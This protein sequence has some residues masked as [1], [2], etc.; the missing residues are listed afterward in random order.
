MHHF[1]YLWRK[2]RVCA[3]ARE[4]ENMSTK[5]Q[6]PSGIRIPA[7]KAINI[8]PFLLA[9][10]LW[11]VL[12]F[13][14]YHY[15]RK[16]EDLS[17]FLF[18]R[19]FLIDGFRTPGG[20]LGIAG[21]FC[22]QFLHLPWL[23]SLIWVLLLVSSF[24]LTRKAFGIPERFAILGLI[25][26]VL[27][28]ISNTSL[29]YGL[30]IMRAQ[31]HYFSP[32]LGYLLSLVPVFIVKR[33]LSKET[34]TPLLA[35]TLIIWT[36]SVYPL[37]GVYALAGTLAAG[38]LVLTSSNATGKRITLLLTSLASVLV[39]PILEYNLYTSIRLAGAWTA[40]LPSPSDEGWEGFVSAPY[41]ILF[42]VTILMPVLTASVRKYTVRSKRDAIW[43][44]SS[45][46]AF[47]LVIWA[48][49]F[50]DVNFSTELAMSY[51]VDNADW[52]QVI[53]SFNK[54]VQKQSRS[55]AKAYESRSRK[56]ARISN[57]EDIVDIV[58]RYE[59][60]FFEPTRTMVMY[61][62]L[63][64]L[65]QDKALDLAFTMKD[66]GRRQNS[67]TQISMAYQS[68]KQFYLYYG[69]ENM[70]YRWCMEDIIE[71]GWS[72]STL[73]YMV[74]YSIVTGEKTLALKHISKLSKALFYRKWADSRKELLS[75]PDVAAVTE[76]YKSIAP[77]LCFND[78]MSND[79]GKPELYIMNHF[80]SRQPVNATAQ[81]DRTALFFA[82]RTQDISKFWERLLY[83]T[84]S[85]DFKTLPLSVQQ[86][87][88]LY[89]NLENDG[90]ELP[91]DKK[92]KDGYDA[93]VK[94]VN[95]HPIRYMK[96][97]LYP[98]YQKFGKT[99]QYY[100]YFIRNLQTY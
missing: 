37:A 55:D 84:N 41:I 3:H 77:L 22:T 42:I 11:A 87:A 70:C 85:N 79:M 66:G 29:G 83:Y 75:N 90:M 49:W 94:Y 43:Q 2:M 82:M 74:E 5:D 18:D 51:A 88:I 71:H 63:A 62:D 53:E 4:N 61:R 65:K 20:I 16:V 34:R 60:R 9:A 39:I 40:G 92:V 64:L 81:Y 17:L 99:F 12:A 15:L 8:L 46:S 67:R 32:T 36:V 76:P 58:D 72:F 35:V 38:A 78:Q 97:S 31:D 50:N 52:K 21:A 44:V 27:L 45:F 13:H 89:S 47:I 56:L 59:N 25:P 28:I 23:G 48:F 57:M 14:E 91:Y 33:E 80:I 93:F 6:K 24:L 1:Y 95:S 96:E 30:F 26:A 7:E 100:Y 10:L 73:K 98:F 86:A 19:A 54:T 68:G 69:L